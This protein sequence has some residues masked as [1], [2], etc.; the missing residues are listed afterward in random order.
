MGYE[1][2]I[3]IVER[4]EYT[5]KKTGKLYVS[6][7]KI[8]SCDLCVMGNNS[9]FYGVFDRPIDFDMFL[10]GVDEHG[11]EIMEFSRSDC[12]GETLKMC[13]LPAL[14]DVLKQAEAREHY[15]RL[16]PLIAM[17][18]AFVDGAEEWGKLKAVRYAH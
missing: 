13:D 16:P 11:R 15:R 4:S 10:P 17:L 7:L 12:Y 3:Y 14:L 2:K 5:D 6:A 8:A 18:Q 1:S 9:A